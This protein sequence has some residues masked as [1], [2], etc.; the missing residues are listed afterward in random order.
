MSN[1]TEL[2]NEFANGKNSQ[3]DNVLGIVMVGASG[4]GKTSL[5]ATM[6]NAINQALPAGIIFEP[7]D[8]AKDAELQEAYE[9]LQV[10][11]GKDVLTEAKFLDGSAD[12]EDYRFRIKDG[13]KTWFEIV[14]VDVPGGWYNPGKN[15]YE[16]LAELVGKADVVIKTVDSPFLVEEGG[17]YSETHNKQAAFFNFLKKAFIIPK[18]R[19]VIFTMLKSEKYTNATFSTSRSGEVQYGEWLWKVFQNKYKATI[20]YIKSEDSIIRCYYSTVSTIGCLEFST[21]LKSK[22]EDGTPKTKKIKFKHNGNRF[23]PKNV[24]IPLLHAVRFYAEQWKKKI[25]IWDKFVNWFTGNLDTFYRAIETISKGDD[26]PSHW[27]EFQEIKNNK[28]Q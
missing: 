23:E 22:N 6:R 15:E 2:S 25:T 7:V 18:D 19:L 5:V 27:T 13:K 28:K 3:G 21:F 26:N 24:H 17:V 1:I 16:R 10:N 11:S 4:T 8:S 9:K 12:I 20:D 14:L